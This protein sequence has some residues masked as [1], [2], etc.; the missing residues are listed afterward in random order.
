MFDLIV[1]N[2]TLPDGTTGIDLACKDG[3]IAAVEAGITA[4]AGEVI[5]ASGYLVSPRS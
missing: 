4:E 1:K 3:V 5:D 2:G